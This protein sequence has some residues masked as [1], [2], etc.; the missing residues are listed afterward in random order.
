MFLFM[1]YIN[2]AKNFMVKNSLQ[3]QRYHNSGWP[4]TRSKTSVM[5]SESQRVK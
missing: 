4:T 2:L 5:L 3:D 1:N